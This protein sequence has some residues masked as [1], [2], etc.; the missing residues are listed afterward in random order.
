M[1]LES[2]IRLFDD[3]KVTDLYP[4]TIGFVHGLA[5]LTRDIA[6]ARL[7]TLFSLVYMSLLIPW[8]GAIATVSIKSLRRGG[9][10]VCARF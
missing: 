9:F 10:I 4:A 1:E 7:L 6:R 5:G 2:A 8:L 3:W